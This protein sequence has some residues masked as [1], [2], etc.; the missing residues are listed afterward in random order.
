MGICYREKVRYVWNDTKSLFLCVIRNKFKKK[1][2]AELQGEFIDGMVR[3]GKACFHHFESI[4]QL[5]VSIS[6]VSG[7]RA[8]LSILLFS[9]EY[10]ESSNE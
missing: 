3:K 1:V 4:F 10:I 7:L 2:C 8:I 5:N 6:P 9:P